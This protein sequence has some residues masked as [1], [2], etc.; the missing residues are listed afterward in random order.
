M[1]SSTYGENDVLQD[2]TSVLEEKE[3]AAKS[4]CA[5]GNNLPCVLYTFLASMALTAALLNTCFLASLIEKN[6]DVDK[7]VC[8]VGLD[9]KGLEEEEERKRH[10]WNNWMITL[11]EDFNEFYFLLDKDKKEWLLNIEGEWEQIIQ[12][13][14]NKWTTDEKS[15]DSSGYVSDILEES[16][17]WNNSQ[18]EDW[19]R[20]KGSQLMEI[21]WEGW[22]NEK[23]SLLNEMI[24]KKWIEWKN[25]KIMSWVT[26]KW[27][28][29]E[30]C[31]WADWEK[32][33][34]YKSLNI[35]ER[36]KWLKWKERTSRESAEW[37]NWINIKECV[38]IH[39]EW[40]KWTDWK[41]NK[42][43]HFK[44]WKDLFIDKWVKEKQWLAWTLKRD[45]QINDTP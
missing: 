6:T 31:Y 40:N 15:L 21:E 34:S 23:D 30:D 11:E 12:E 45:N 20:T 2:N 13:M 43:T 19:I 22:V 28:T 16:S 26:S 18:W 7:P 27:K 38:Y 36:A 29:D 4:C 14:E 5:K 42:R 33:K 37:T 32:N 10:T 9:E 41:N 1:E 25:S 17:T 8:L 3:K 44:I 39:N 24:V 35:T